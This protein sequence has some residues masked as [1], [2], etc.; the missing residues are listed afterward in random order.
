MIVV[1]IQTYGDFDIPG[2]DTIMVAPQAM[3]KKIARELKKEAEEMFKNTND[4]EGVIKWLRSWGFET[5][6]ILNITIGGNL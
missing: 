5:C 6:N 1:N 4:T 3:S 2:T